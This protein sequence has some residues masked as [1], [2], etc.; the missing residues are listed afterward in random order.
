MP[1]WIYNIGEDSNFIAILPW[2]CLFISMHQLIFKWLENQ[3]RQ[4]DKEAKPRQKTKM[5]LVTLCQPHIWCAA[6]WTPAA[7][8][9]SKPKN[10]KMK[11]KINWVGELTNWALSITFSLSG[12]F[13]SYRRNSFLKGC[14]SQKKWLRHRF[15]ECTDPRLEK[16]M[17]HWEHLGEIEIALSNIP[18]HWVCKRA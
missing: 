4:R 11:S 8:A 15:Q 14:A 17:G 10:M 7:R 13:I 9:S 18:V 12:A 3:L 2:L 16:I 5:W 6:E 1:W